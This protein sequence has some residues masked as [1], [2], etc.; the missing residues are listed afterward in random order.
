MRPRGS[1]GGELPPFFRVGPNR[2]R[3]LRDARDAYPA[4]LAAIASAREEILL[5]MY[6]IGADVAGVR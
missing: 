4:M 5:E 3:L 6:W 2:V 1:D